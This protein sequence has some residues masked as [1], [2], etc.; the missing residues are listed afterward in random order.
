MPDM[1]NL[2][3][4]QEPE[5]LSFDEFPL[6]VLVIKDFID[7]CCRPCFHFRMPHK[8]SKPGNI[9]RSAGKKSRFSPVPKKSGLRQVT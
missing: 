9:T 7:V 4:G 2:D 6:Y 3:A 8:N 5:K 1:S